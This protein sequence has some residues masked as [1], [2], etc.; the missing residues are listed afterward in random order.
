MP[1]V[2]VL[3]AGVRKTASVAYKC[4]A[5]GTCSAM[6]RLFGSVAAIWPRLLAPHECYLVAVCAHA[7]RMLR[8]SCS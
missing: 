3:D 4:E 5:K 7:A 6:P 8:V 2:A 1:S